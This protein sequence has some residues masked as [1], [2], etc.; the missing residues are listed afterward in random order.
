MP[1][2]LYNCNRNFQM[3][4]SSFQVTLT[5]SYENMEAEVSSLRFQLESEKT[6]YKKMQMDLQRELQGAFD[7]NT[8]LTT[9]LDGKVPKSRSDLRSFGKH[10]FAPQ[11]LYLAHTLQ[12]TALDNWIIRPLICLCLVS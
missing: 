3:L 7:E 8:K 6:R 11:V 2:A 9:L 1:I 10:Y 5:A 4:Y 12:Y